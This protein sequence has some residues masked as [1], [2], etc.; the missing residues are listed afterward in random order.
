MD[1][2]LLVT[3]IVAVLGSS[4]ITAVVSSIVNR[5]KTQAET[6]QITVSSEIELSG[7]TLN[8]AK[9]VKAMYD[10]LKRDYN[11]MKKKSEQQED[12]IDEL[13]SKHE[14]LETKYEELQVKYDRVV[15]FLEKLGY[16][17]SE[18]FI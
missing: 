4:V 5:K 3:I 14:D 6:K 11:E 10:D 17:E 12:K 15:G 13:Q 8:Y 16:A 18:A 2:N 7:A 9:E 1:T